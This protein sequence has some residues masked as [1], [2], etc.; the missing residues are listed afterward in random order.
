MKQS[1][2]G[3]QKLRT[4]SSLLLRPSSAYKTCTSGRAAT[5]AFPRILFS[6]PGRAYS[7]Q[8][9]HQVS[10]FRNMQRVI[11]WHPKC[12]QLLRDAHRNPMAALGKRHVLALFM[13]RRKRDG[14]LILSC[15]RWTGGFR[16]LGPSWLRVLRVNGQ[17]HPARH[18]PPY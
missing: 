1:R 10:S 14:V 9:A 3:L 17:S 12:L 5:A 4:H 2:V 7:R 15:V 8:G 16:T 18:R 11:K 13:S 6:P